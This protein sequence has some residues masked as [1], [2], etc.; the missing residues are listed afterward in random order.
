MNISLNNSRCIATSQ[1]DEIES[2]SSE[3]GFYV[4][5]TV[6]TKLQCGSI[7]CHLKDSGRSRLQQ[8][9]NLVEE[10]FQQMSH[11]KERPV[12]TVDNVTSQFRL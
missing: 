12:Q 8:M 7:L 2:S 6:Q 4:E 3:S 1:L 5:E 11:L 9:S 10:P